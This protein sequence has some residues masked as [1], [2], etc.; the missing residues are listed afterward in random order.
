MWARESDQNP[1]ASSVWFGI[2]YTTTPILKTS[3]NYIDR[4]TLVEK[5]YI[6]FGTNS[7]P[8]FEFLIF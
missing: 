7:I 8:I 6:L 3:Y 2:D 5:K 4:K 1:E